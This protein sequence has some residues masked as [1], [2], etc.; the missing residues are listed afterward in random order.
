VENSP[1]NAVRDEKNYSIV[2]KAEVP[3]VAKKKEE[4]PVFK[5][6]FER[7]VLSGNTL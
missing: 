7:F 5:L 1:A 2:C 3:N 6:L 4:Q